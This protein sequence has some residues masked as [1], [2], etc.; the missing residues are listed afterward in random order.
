MISFVLN[1][2]RVDVELPLLDY[3]LPVNLIDINTVLILL[4]L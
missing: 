4:T 2:V 3:E 1:T